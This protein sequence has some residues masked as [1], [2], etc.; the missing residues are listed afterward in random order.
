MPNWVS[1]SIEFIGDMENIEK[2]YAEIGNP[3]AEDEDQKIIDF[4]K[5]IPMPECLNIEASSKTNLAHAYYMIKTFNKL[6]ETVAFSTLSE[7]EIINKVEK[8][9]NVSS[10][11]MLKL[12]KQAEENIKLYKHM[13]WYNW[14]VTNWGTKWNAC[15]CCKDG[16][17]LSI[18]TAWSFPYPIMEKLSE[19][20][21]KHNVDFD[22]SWADEDCGSNTG[23]FSSCENDFFYDYN[24]DCS[25]EA[26]KTYI[27]CWGESD[28]I[29]EDGHGEYIHYECT[30]EGC[31]NYCYQV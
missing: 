18:Q 24:D 6:P 23:K 20:C 29:G 28:C 11:E 10:Y 22:G 16:I 27:E 3:D 13:D 9:V 30:P 7:Q 26:Y 15:S 8:D 25:S 14:C 2:V 5:L 4:N 17:Y 1:T 31:P 21:R 19:I 12:G